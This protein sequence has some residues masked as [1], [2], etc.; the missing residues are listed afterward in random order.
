M[1]KQILSWVL[2]MSLLLSL[3]PAS[4]GAADGTCDGTHSSGWTKLTTIN[5]N[6]FYDGGRYWL[7]GDVTYSGAGYSLTIS[8][9]TD[10]ILCLNGHTM[11][12]GGSTINVESGATL[13]ICDCSP[14]QTGTI[15]GR[16][17]GSFHELISVEGGTLNLESG[18]IS[19][20]VSNGNRSLISVTDGGTLN[21][22]GGT[23]SLNHTSG[24][25]TVQAVKLSNSTGSFTGGRVSLTTETTN[26]RATTVYQE[27]GTVTV[28][29]SAALS[30]QTKNKLT[31]AGYGVLCVT[32]DGKVT[33]GGN[34]SI[35]ASLTEG[36][37][38]AA[39]S[40]GML[41]S[42]GTGTGTA[43]ITGGEIKGGLAVYGTA[44]ISGGSFA[45]IQNYGT[46]T[47]T[48]GTVGNETASMGDRLG[49]MA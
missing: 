12:M 48:G 16:I 33:V 18:T 29:G 30:F 19:S 40:I 21:V 41:T 8:K 20:E 43:T 24:N 1:K 14:G 34:S 49:I 47:M 10:V 25:G 22:T 23:I 2:T 28:G 39:L 46:L 38:A 3:L 32:K 5:Q 6:S 15:K 31:V 44:E 13:T 17:A 42:D 26:S 27:G 35:E 37:I 9:D 45:N 36:S 4:A 7:S 11:D